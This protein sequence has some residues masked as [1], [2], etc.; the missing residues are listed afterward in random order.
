MGLSPTK[1]IHLFNVGEAVWYD[2]GP[3]PY[4]PF[5]PGLYVILERQDGRFNRVPGP[6]YTVRLP[7]KNTIAVH[8]M[9]LHVPTKT[10]RT[11]F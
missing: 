11:L 2:G 7:N 5:P 10:Q 9:N 3:T 8:E 4:E 1:I 6:W